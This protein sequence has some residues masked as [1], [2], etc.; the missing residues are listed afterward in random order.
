M[1]DHDRTQKRELAQAERN[2]KGIV[3]WEVFYPRTETPLS[4]GIF[5]LQKVITRTPRRVLEKNAYWTM[6]AEWRL[7]IGD[8]WK[9][10][11]Q[12]LHQQPYDPAKLR[13]YAADVDEAIRRHKRRQ[14]FLVKDD[15][16]EVHEV[17]CEFEREA[18]RRVE[19]RFGRQVITVEVKE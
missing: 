14:T 6:K 8:P 12:A 11:D 13:Q 19:D 5:D 4:S 10:L 15:T 18:K 7:A 3:L 9:E 17:F 2:D 1:A 16:G